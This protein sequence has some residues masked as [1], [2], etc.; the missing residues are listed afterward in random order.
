MLEPF[1]HEFNTWQFSAQRYAE[2]KARLNA[3]TRTEI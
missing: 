3:R 1:R 2:L